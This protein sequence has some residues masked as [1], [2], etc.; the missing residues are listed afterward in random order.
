L[1]VDLVVLR[2]CVWVARF[3]LH[4]SGLH[5]RFPLVWFYRLHTHGFTGSVG[6]RFTVW[7]WFT[8]HHT[9]YIHRFGFGSVTRLH[10]YSCLVVAG[11][12]GCYIWLH[13]FDL[14]LVTF[15]F[16]LHVWL[17]ICYVMLRVTVGCTLIGSPVTPPP[18][19]LRL[20]LLFWLVP[21]QLHGWLRLLRLILDYVPFGRLLLR[22]LFG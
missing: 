21:T 6:L 18:P 12:F 9:V 16:R 22:W 15:G 13:L 11:T 8:A 2:F 14:R 1:F 5:T 20:R 19:P 4:G 7:F 10:V 3:W 17:L